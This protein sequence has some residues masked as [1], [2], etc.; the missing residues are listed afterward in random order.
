MPANVTTSPSP[1]MRHHPGLLPGPNRLFVAIV[2]AMGNGVASAT[3][4][5]DTHEVPDLVDFNTSFT[6]SG[7]DLSRFRRSNLIGAGS[8]LVDLHVNDRIIGRET[9]KFR[10]GEAR[11]DMVACFTATQLERLGLDIAKLDVAAIPAANDCAS[12][13]TFVVDASARFDT[14]ALRLDV[15]IPQVSLRR[16]PRGYIEPS[17]WDRGT[18]AGTVAYSAHAYRS[19][20][21]GS[22]PASGSGSRTADNVYLGLDNGLNVGDWR[23]RHRASAQWRSGDTVK[24]QGVGAYAQRDVTRW[25]AQLTVG[26]SFTSGR[27]F[28]STGFRGINLATDDRM[29]P[30]GQNGFAPIVRGVA[31]TQAQVTIKQN[32]YLLRELSV[33]P[34]EF[35]IDD[36][37][38]TG[39]GGDLL[40]TVTESDGSFHT[41]DVPYASVPQLMRPRTGRFELTAGK[42]RSHAAE[43]TPYLLEGTYQ[44]GV[45]N[46]ITMYGG[47][48]ATHDGSYRGAVLG[49]AFNSPIGA[50]S[51]DLLGA[52]AKM[53]GQPQQGGY[54][55]RVS[56]A[57]NLPAT[58][59]NFALASYHY[60]SGRHVSVTDAVAWNDQWRRDPDRALRGMQSRPRVQT[61]LTINQP[62]G[63]HFGS[64]FITGSHRSHHGGQGNVTTYNAGYS[65]RFRRMGYSLSASRTQ[66]LNGRRD[67]QYYV[68]ANIPLGLTGSRRADVLS[69]SLTRDSQGQHHVRVSMNGSLGDRMRSS[70][71]VHANHST[72]KSHGD[73][74]GA[75]LSWRG[76]NVSTSGS[77]SQDSQHRQASF[78][79]SGSVVMH[80]GGVTLAPQVGD[81]IAIV[82]AKGAQGARINGSTRINRHGYG[83]VASLTPYRQNEINLDPRGISTDVE[84]ESTRQKI[85]PRAGAIVRATFDTKTGRSL[86]IRALRD[87]GD[88]L[89]FGA[90]V[91]DEAG[92]EVG[93]VGQGGQMFV[94]TSQEAGS[95]N[96]RWGEA[97]ADQCH[98]AY[99]AALQG[100]AGSLH[101]IQAHCTA[102][103]AGTR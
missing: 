84:F 43:R 96:V 82:E 24:W 50:V 80:Q 42:I 29:R 9:V 2:L 83:V 6:G 78:S 71:G 34:G 60:A 18:T 11:D 67:N 3:A 53:G 51:V 17:L 76:D 97:P 15:S 75:N 46:A 101:A 27:L 64:L 95:L 88:N 35:E 12:I 93:V 98:V 74:T 13:E 57:K 45:N 19:V 21:R 100:T 16:Q 79:A 54:S 103:A 5:D 20:R 68:T 69:T 4:I 1:P 44:Y 70:Y 41:F 25:R 40:V 81:T 38:A 65:G 37:N 49:G 32:G 30:D 7:V 63:D 56:F 72:G 86:L 62:L 85:T 48:Q 52:S 10:Q 58:R 36:L 39:F 31:R 102:A 77:Y 92:S 90:Q 99:N 73:S 23:I 91:F 66:M 26:D 28:D 33:A 94:R 61:Q 8:Y 89:P 87:N 14:S 22:R 59:T 47:V 55:V